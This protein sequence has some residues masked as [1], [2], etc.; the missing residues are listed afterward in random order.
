M[1]RLDLILEP[2]GYAGVTPYR[3]LS[4]AAR[5]YISADHRFLHAILDRGEQSI[6]DLVRFAS[7]DHSDDLMDLDPLLIDLFRALGTAEALPFFVSVIRRNTG[8]VPDDLVEG[9]VELGA[10]ALDPLLGLLE[11]ERVRAVLDVT[12]PEPL[13]PGH[14]L[15]DAKGVLITPHM[16]GDSPLAQ[17]HAWEL[18]AKQVRRYARGEALVNVVQGDY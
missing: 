16:A 8:D 2:E 4:A 10:A 14:P 7:E 18:V 5:G 6:P 9:V 11:E 15:W 3:L 17:Q 13:P 1:P 12:N